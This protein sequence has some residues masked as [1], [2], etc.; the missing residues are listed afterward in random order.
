[1][2][3]EE[4]EK[5]DCGPPPRKVFFFETLSELNQAAPNHRDLADASQ[6]A[7]AGYTT[8]PS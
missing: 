4:I 2:K 6:R 8:G 7:L 1:M 5:G 3:E